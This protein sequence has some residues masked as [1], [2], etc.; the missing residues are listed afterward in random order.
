M[1]LPLYS[2]S[3]S[4][5]RLIVFHTRKLNSRRHAHT[6][7]FTEMPRAGITCLVTYSSKPGWHDAVDKR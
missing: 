1:I 3:R 7:M 4:C 6:S 5:P 2:R